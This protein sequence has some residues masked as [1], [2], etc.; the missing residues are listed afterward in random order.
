MDGY[1]RTLLSKWGALLPAEAV[2][3]LERIQRAASRLDLL[4]RDV[5]AY[6]RLGQDEVQ[7]QPLALDELLED[8]LE[9]HPEFETA[10]AINIRKP[11]LRVMGHPALLTQCLSN[12]VAN[13]LKFVAPGVS[14]QLSVASEPTGGKIRISVSDNGI[15]IAP[16]H[17][18]RVFRIFSRVHSEKV[19]PGTG[20][21]LAIVKKAVARMGGELG[22]ESQPGKGSTF[23]FTLA[24]ASG[25][26]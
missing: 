23:W 1:A 16:E 19:Y 14:P 6:S 22:F 7:L 9:Q 26:D 5:L 10:A 3:C 20:I 8:M 17:R 24:S 25:N 18:D 2:H 21:G 11:L 15:G 4:V 13:G 12:L